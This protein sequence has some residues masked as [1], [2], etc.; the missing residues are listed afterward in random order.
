[1][2]VGPN[3][4]PEKAQAGARLHAA[5][6]QANHAWHASWA[7]ASA[8]NRLRPAR[9]CRGRLACQAPLPDLWCTRAVSPATAA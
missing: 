4:R 5:V 8:P 1:M 6:N 2:P 3:R 9:A 7:P